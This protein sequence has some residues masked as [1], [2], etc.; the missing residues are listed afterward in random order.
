[1]NL[2]RG[3]PEVLEV[4]IGSAVLVSW[5]AFVAAY[6]LKAVRHAGVREHQSGPE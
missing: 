4:T 6:L 3:G 2:G 5:C 1:M